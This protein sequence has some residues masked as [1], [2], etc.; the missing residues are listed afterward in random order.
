MDRNSKKER[1]N[2]SK[3]YFIVSAKWERCGLAVAVLLT[4]GAKSR[5][6]VATTV[7]FHGVPSTESGFLAFPF[8]QS[9]SSQLLSL[10]FVPSDSGRRR[11]GATSLP[12]L[13]A[14]TR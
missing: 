9:S 11:R 13:A 7:P 4:S 12:T 14:V 2:E 6:S 5:S 10:S 3:N 1:K 8:H